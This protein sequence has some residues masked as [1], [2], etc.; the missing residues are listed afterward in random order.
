M[1]LTYRSATYQ[2]TSPT[3]ETSS[4][5][6]FGKYR[7]VDIKEWRELFA[8]VNSYPSQTLKAN[9]ELQATKPLKY[10]AA[11]IQQWRQLF[12][13]VNCYGVVN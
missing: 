13:A 5:K 6:T 10:R 1:Q 4:M 2:F 12:G 8:G 7:G 9:S 3:R 11:D